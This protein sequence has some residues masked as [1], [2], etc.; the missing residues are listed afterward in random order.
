MDGCM[1][2]F[3][4]L[5]IDL[6]IVAL[7]IGFLSSMFCSDMG[8]EWNGGIWVLSIVITVIIVG[9]FYWL[10]HKFINKK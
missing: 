10:L 9:L 5:I 8:V 2:T 3:L 1:F 7:C 4:N 6:V